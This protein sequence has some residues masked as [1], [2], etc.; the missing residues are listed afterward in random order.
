MTWTLEIELDW[1][2][3][4]R[5]AQAWEALIREVVD[6]LHRENIV[7]SDIRLVQKAEA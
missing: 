5:D 7:V 4:G 6:P 2:H 3:D 1:P